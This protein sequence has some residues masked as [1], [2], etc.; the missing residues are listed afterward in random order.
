MTLDTIRFLD[1][2]RENDMGLTT[3][4]H[5]V[6]ETFSR[7]VPHFSV[8]FK[9]GIHSEEVHVWAVAEEVLEIVPWLPEEVLGTLTKLTLH[10]GQDSVTIVTRI[11]E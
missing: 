11:K 9:K 3:I 7:D 8:C 1:V 2:R 10:A 5:Y 6:R 4:N